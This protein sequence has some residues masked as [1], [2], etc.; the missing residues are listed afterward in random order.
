[1][2]ARATG[3]GIISFGMVSI[4]VK[5]YS[6]VDS[7]K[8]IRFNMLRSDGSRLKQQYISAVDGEVVEKED[9]IKGYEFSKGQYVLFSDE[10]MKAMDAKST[11]EIEIT[12]FVP[13]DQVNQNCAA[14]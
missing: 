1:M 2:A 5:L 3:S 9:R 11:N 6:T 7:T 4:P 12:E 8:A 10:E 13:A 14:A